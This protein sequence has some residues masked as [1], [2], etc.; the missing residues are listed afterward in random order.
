MDVNLSIAHR[1]LLSDKIGVG[2][3]QLDFRFRL[4]KEARFRPSVVLGITPPGSVSPVL[5]HDYLVATKNI[6]TSIGTFRITGGYGT[7]YLI[8]RRNDKHNFW[9]ELKLEEKAEFRSGNNYLIGFFGGITYL[10]VDFGG[11]MIEYNT[12]TINAGAFVKLWDWL[13]LQAY[14]Y[15]G[16]KAA[17]TIAA[18]SPLNFK[19][20]TLRKHEKSLE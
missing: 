20:N 1:P 8:M 4:L 13:H 2:D 6:N 17:F 9:Q 14:A 10:P 12:T 11:V 18:N 16:K 5:S 7:P 19:P 3:R 15:E